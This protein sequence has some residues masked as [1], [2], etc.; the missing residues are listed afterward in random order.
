M[1][2][3]LGGADYQV[4]VNLVNSMFCRTP[5]WN[6]R[7][8]NLALANLDHLDTLRSDITNQS[9]LWALEYQISRI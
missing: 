9:A 1:D 4:Q 2:L 3:S 8:R 5:E 7:L 6:V